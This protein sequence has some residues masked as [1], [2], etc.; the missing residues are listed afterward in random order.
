MCVAYTLLT[1]YF[2]FILFF[3]VFCFSRFDVFIVFDRLIAFSFLINKGKTAEKTEWIHASECVCVRMCLC[4][5]VKKESCTFCLFST[6]GE[7]TTNTPQ[8]A[9]NNEHTFYTP[10]QQAAVRI[11]KFF[12][13][14]FHFTSSSKKKEHEI[15][16]T[17]EWTSAS[18][19][20]KRR[21][22]KNGFSYVCIWCRIIFAAVNLFAQSVSCDFLCHPANQP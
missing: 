1:S 18:N 8:P 21:K 16:R 13:S 7:K 22:K 14:N 4:L 19:A 2:F 20:N 6:I 17:S 9:S 5:C 11:S 3:G 15:R 10:Q 12:F